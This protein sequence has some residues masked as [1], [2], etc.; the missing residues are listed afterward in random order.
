MAITVGF[1]SKKNN[2]NKTK[3]KRIMTPSER[4]KW[5]TERREFGDRF[6]I[7]KNEV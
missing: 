1:V 7:L 3:T 4:L 2:L 6:E 5:I